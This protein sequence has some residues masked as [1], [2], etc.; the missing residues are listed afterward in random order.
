MRRVVALAVIVVA[1]SCRDAP[2]PKSENDPPPTIRATPEPDSAAT[3]K[4]VVSTDSTR[5]KVPPKS[6]KKPDPRLRDSA[7]GPK[8]TIDSLGQIK[9]IKKP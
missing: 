1:S 9:P 5:A 8:Y 6:A 7:F 2:K 3:G 4:A